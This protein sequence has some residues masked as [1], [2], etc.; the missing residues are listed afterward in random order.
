[1]KKL[2]TCLL[3]LCMLVNLFVMAAADEPII[4]QEDIDALQAEVETLRSDIEDAEAKLKAL[5]RQYA[6]E[7]RDRDVIFAE[8]DIILLS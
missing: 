7:N 5:E 1:M 6:Y 4:T 8:T 3:A 2:Y